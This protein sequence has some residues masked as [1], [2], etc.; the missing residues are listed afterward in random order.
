MF[1]KRF[2]DAFQKEYQCSS[3]SEST[4]ILEL[5]TACVYTDKTVPEILRTDS[6]MVGLSAKLH[7]LAQEVTWHL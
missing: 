2:S 5:T 1:T 3:D 7:M 6:V 4:Y